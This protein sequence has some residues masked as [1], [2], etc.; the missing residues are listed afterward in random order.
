MI[1]QPPT[2]AFV[3]P[4]GSERLNWAPPSGA[5]PPGGTTGGFVVTTSTPSLNLVNFVA[6]GVGTDSTRMV[7]QNSAWLTKLYLK[8]N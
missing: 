3:N 6:A 4:C 5:T 7:T 1:D 2:D 8:K